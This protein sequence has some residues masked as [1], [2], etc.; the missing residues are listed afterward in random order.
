MEELLNELLEDE[1]F[2][3]F[4]KDEIMEVVEELGIINGKVEI[5]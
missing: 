2:E 3:S 5:L 4:S 1:F